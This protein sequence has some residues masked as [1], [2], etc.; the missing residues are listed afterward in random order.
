M[1]YWIC[2]ANSAEK[3]RQ[4]VQDSIAKGWRP[5]GGLSVVQSNSTADWWYFQ[6]MIL[7]RPEDARDDDEPELA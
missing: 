5:I 6:A 1:N 2:E 7:D 3:L 4:L